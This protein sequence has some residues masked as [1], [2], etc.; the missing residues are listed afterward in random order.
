[1]LTPQIWVLVRQTPGTSGGPP[2]EPAHV[3]G[4]LKLR[5]SPALLESLGYQDSRS[6]AVALPTAKP[7]TVR[8]GHILSEADAVATRHRGKWHWSRWRLRVNPALTLSEAAEFLG[9]F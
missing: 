7:C 4:P 1:M 5:V 8:D 6:T 2:H 3:W 9:G